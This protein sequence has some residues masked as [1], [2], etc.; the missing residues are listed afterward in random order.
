MSVWILS[1]TRMGV[2]LI[3][4]WTSDGIGAYKIPPKAWNE[5]D[6]INSYELQV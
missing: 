1:R 4:D 5:I 2:L 3:V 6:P